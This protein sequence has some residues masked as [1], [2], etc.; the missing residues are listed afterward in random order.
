MFRFAD[1]GRVWVPVT[2]PR[3]NTEGGEAVTIHLLQDIYT[4]DELKQRD[5]E[6]LAHT[7]A[8]LAPDGAPVTPESLQA[9]LDDVT[10]VED[11]DIAELLRRTHDWR[12]VVN[13]D[14][15]PLGFTAERLRA[16]L[17]V[18]WFFVAARQALFEVSRE[19]VAKNSL[20]G[21]AGGQ[22]RVQA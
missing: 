14:D 13:S 18:N 21:P 7:M 3:G 12:G 16:L 6:A 10:R 9:T 1:I 8:K 17:R 4:R 15:Q 22:T 20:P 5:R 2:L 11:A 19:G